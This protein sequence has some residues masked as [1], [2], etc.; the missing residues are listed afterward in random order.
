MSRQHQHILN[1]NIDTVLFSPTGDDLLL[2]QSPLL[3]PL[4]ISCL[5]FLVCLAEIFLDQYQSAFL[6]QQQHKTCHLTGQLPHI[7]A[8]LWS[9]V[10]VVMLLL[11]TSCS[12][13]SSCTSSFSSSS[14]LAGCKCCA[15]NLC[16]TS[17]TLRVDLLAQASRTLDN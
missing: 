5:L 10:V 17:S 6:Q 4:L 3:L 7:C 11:L 16:T 2:R 12:S 8:H 13:L 15:I 1:V 9:V 14:Q